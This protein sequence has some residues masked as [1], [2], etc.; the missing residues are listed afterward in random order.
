MKLVD[1]RVVSAAKD[2]DELFNGDGSVPVARLGR[3]AGRVLDAL[4]FQVEWLLRRARLLR[5]RLHLAGSG[6]RDRCL[7]RMR[8]H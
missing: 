8:T 5:G 7:L 2:D 4:P 6:A 3:R 1:D